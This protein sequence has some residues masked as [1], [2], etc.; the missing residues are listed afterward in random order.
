[1]VQ[2]VDV[3]G[4]LHQLLRAYGFTVLGTRQV[5]LKHTPFGM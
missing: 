1:M 4:G 5:L 2:S 3:G